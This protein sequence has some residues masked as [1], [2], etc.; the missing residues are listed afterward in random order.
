MD[1]NFGIEAMEAMIRRSLTT[2]DGADLDDM[3]DGLDGESRRK[4]LDRPTGSWNETAIHPAAKHGLL[5]K[6]DPFLNGCNLERKNS[7]VKTAFHLAA[8]RGHVDVDAQPSDAQSDAEL[9]R[10][11]GGSRQRP[12]EDG[13]DVKDLAGRQKK[14]AVPRR[15]RERLSRRTDVH[16]KTIAGRTVDDK[17]DY[18]T[19]T[20][21]T[22]T[23]T[24]TTATTTTSFCSESEF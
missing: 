7:A 14:H 15:R 12:E 18:T 11:E 5:T 24:T 6:L 21:T 22:T 13:N 19:T 8:D 9:P 1:G 16:R 10:F 23:T 4:L 3:L 2:T 17:Q 20:A